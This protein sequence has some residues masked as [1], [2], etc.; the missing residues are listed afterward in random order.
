MDPKQLL[1]KSLTKRLAEPLH[2]NNQHL[3][4]GHELEPVRVVV[5]ATSAGVLIATVPGFAMHNDCHGQ[6]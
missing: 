3:R 5:L 1:S 4:R 6:R 2:Q